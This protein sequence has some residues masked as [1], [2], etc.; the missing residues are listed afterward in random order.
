MVTKS[1]K[2]GLGRKNK[3]Q[4]RG[5]VKIVQEGKERREKQ[6][7]QAP[8]KGGDVPGGVTRIVMGKENNGK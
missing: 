4:G 5:N 1:R 8:P 6:P 3:K 7:P 2:K